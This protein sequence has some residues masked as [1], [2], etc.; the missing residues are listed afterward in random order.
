MSKHSPDRGW[1]IGT[2]LAHADMFDFAGFL[3]LDHGLDGPLN[4]RHFIKAVDVVHVDLRQAQSL[5]RLLDGLAAV[6][7]AGIDGDFRPSAARS[8]DL[9]DEL[10]P[11]EY[12]FAL[13]WVRGEPIAD[14][15][16]GVVV[17][18][19]LRGLWMSAM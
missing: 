17:F 5:E 7:G 13:L 10:G 19:G 15:V 8:I 18:V 14:D 9:D 2:A 6:L 16:F 4:R 11:E 12:V 1:R 3:Q